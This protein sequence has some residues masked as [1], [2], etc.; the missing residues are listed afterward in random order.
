[1]GDSHCLASSG[2]EVGTVEI[3]PVIE[4]DGLPQGS[5]GN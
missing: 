2:G 1:M 5:L 3:R 4:V